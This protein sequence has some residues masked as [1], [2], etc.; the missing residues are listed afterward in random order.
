MTAFDLARTAY[1]NMG[2]PVRTA[3]SIEYEAFARVTRRLKSAISSGDFPALAQ[4]M[5]ENRRLWNH[6]AVHVADPANALPT[7]LRARL[8]YLAD[9]THETT[10]KVL[11]RETGAGSLIEINAAIMRGLRHGEEAA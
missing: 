9:Y 8:F 5:H 4:A 3:R 1:T 10:K 11:R 6:F 7:D 2:A